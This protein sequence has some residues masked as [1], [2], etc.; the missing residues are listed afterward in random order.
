VHSLGVALERGGFIPEQQ[1]AL[2]MK[3]LRK[4]SPLLLTLNN[5]GP[6][7]FCCFF[8]VKVTVR[9][10]EGKEKLPFILMPALGTV[11]QCSSLISKIVRKSTSFGACCT[12]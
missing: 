4:L 1:Q 2:L 3:A 7:N 6:Y 9:H 12:F 5:D 8:E 11:C 10:V